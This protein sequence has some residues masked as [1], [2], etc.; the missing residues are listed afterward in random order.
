MAAP[1]CA[2]LARA[3]DDPVA[4]L[5]L[6]DE[7]E[8]WLERGSVGHCHFW[9]RRDAIDAALAIGDLDRALRH[10][11]AL[12]RYTRAEPLPWSDFHVAR[13]RTS[14]EWRRSRSQSAR[15]ALHAL[16][17]Q[18]RGRRIGGAMAAIEAELAAG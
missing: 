14:V 13:G 15:D 3:S 18:A 7:G 8:A 2:T 1:L 6:L 12:Q 9:F 16:H 4:A 11:D 17:A 10:C 5:R